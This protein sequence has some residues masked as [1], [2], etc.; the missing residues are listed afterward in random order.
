MARTWMVVHTRTRAHRHTVVVV[1]VLLT[2]VRRFRQVETRYFGHTRDGINDTHTRDTIH[3]NIKH[4]TQRETHQFC[5]NDIPV[6][7][8]IGIF[9]GRDVPVEASI[10]MLRRWEYQWKL[11]LVRVFLISGVASRSACYR[12]VGGHGERF[13]VRI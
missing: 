12:C 5:K 11:P 6:E 9:S 8:S 13:A 4:A 7:A 10:G 2:R 3:V 1:V